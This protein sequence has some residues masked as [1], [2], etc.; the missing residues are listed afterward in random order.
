MPR[1]IKP[2]YGI[3]PV[4]K[5]PPLSFKNDEIDRLFK[6]L[7]PV[8]GDHAEIVARLERCA[9]DYLWRRNQNQQ[10]PTRAEQNA[11]LKEVG[12]L[13]KDLE[14]R[15]RTLDMDTEWELIAMLPEPS[16]NSLSHAIE[17]L[18][19]RLG[20]LVD[21]A[22]QALR[23]GEKKSGPRIR[24]YLE[25]AVM[26]LANIYQDATGKP[27]SHNPKLRTTE[28]VGEPRSESGRF[29]VAFF[30]IV[31]PDV[32]PTSLSSAMAIAVKFGR[33]QQEAATS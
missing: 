28:Y 29:I 1:Q 25:R 10:K 4:Q 17:D 6:A 21:T 33:G 9:Q 11:A 30:G 31:D 32:R 26:E 8:Q 15:L 2:R 7:A 18:A 3:D 12:R 5:V 20:S 16:E 27:F 22:E 14:V 19:D 13:A 24:A 23:A